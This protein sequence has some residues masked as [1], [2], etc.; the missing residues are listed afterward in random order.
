[1]IF[2][3]RIETSDAASFR[4][5]L[6]GVCRE[7]KFLATAQAPS[8]ARVESFI[9][10][11]IRKDL[12]QFVAVSGERIVGWCDALPGDYGSAHVGRVGM[13][14]AKEFRGRG[15]GCSLAQATIQKARD[16]GLEK[17]E[18]SV[19]ASNRP[20]VSLYKKLGFIKEGRQKRGR[21]VDGIYDDVLLMG[22][23]LAVPVPVP[24]D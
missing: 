21:C 24:A 3:R 18:L 10:E 5:V 19:Y 11:N 6:D 8:L 15:I 16:I 7:R 14:V 1:M 20:A 4:E 9:A 2:I 12:P 13:G 22:M 23:L 17:L